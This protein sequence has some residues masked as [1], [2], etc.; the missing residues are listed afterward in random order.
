[1]MTFVKLT[2][3]NFFRQKQNITKLEDKLNEAMG[4]KRFDP[5]LSFATPSKNKVKL[6]LFSALFIDI[7]VFFVRGVYFLNKSIS[8]LP[9]PVSI[10]GREGEL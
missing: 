7:V 5:R 9:P 8:P 3:F 6:S 4:V 10:F 1:M 2:I